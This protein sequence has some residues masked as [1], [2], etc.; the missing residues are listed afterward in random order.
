[1]NELVEVVLNKNSSGKALQGT[2]ID[3]KTDGILL[4]TEVGEKLFIPFTAIIYIR[5]I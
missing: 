1:M 2:L 4:R 5:F 3:K